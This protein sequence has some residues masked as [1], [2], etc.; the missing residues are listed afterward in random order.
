MQEIPVVLVTTQPR[1]RSA[2]SETAAFIHAHFIESIASRCLV[3]IRSIHTVL[4]ALIQA[5]STA[6]DNRINFLIAR[7]KFA[8]L[9][10]PLPKG[11]FHILKKEM[12]NIVSS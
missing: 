6:S 10:P 2:L 8:C 9:A 4:H 7:V 11:P 3:Q 1:P 5:E 12:T